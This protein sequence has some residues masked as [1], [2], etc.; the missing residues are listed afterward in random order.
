MSILTRPPTMVVRSN[1]REAARTERTMAVHRP[2]R[3]VPSVA[4]WNEAARKQDEE[5][6]KGTKTRFTLGRGRT[7]TKA[8]LANRIGRELAAY[9]AIPKATL[10]NFSTRA[11]SLQLLS[12]FAAEFV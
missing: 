3:D 1:R 12:R 2:W 6:R 10:K 11:S 5:T 7:D 4:V 9:H 8:R